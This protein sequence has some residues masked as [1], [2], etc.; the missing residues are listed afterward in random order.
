MPG[1]CRQ[2][3]GEDRA[4]AVKAAFG[5]HVP[6]FFDPGRVLADQVVGHVLHGGG[7]GASAAFDDRLAPAT[8]PP[9][10]AHTRCGTTSAS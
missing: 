10:N 5:Q 8:P 9:E 3:A 4:A 1:R 6:V 2:R 7:H